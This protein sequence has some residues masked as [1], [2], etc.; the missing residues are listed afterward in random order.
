MNPK[1]YEFIFQESLLRAYS[2][3]K[4]FTIKVKYNGEMKISLIRLMCIIV[5]LSVRLTCLTYL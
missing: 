2:T 1:C 5:T 3:L 4:C